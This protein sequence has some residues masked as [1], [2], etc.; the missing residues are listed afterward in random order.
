MNTGVMKTEEVHDI[1]QDMECLKGKQESVDSQLVTMRRE[2]EA[3]W[4]EVAIL[5]QKHHKQQQIVDKLIQFL[6]TF[7]Q[8]CGVPGFKRKVTHS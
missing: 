8:N 1:L 6:V 3:L 5:R 4:R 7:V 2:N